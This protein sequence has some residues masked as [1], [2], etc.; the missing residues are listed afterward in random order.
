MKYKVISLRQSTNP[1]VPHTFACRRTKTTAYIIN[2]SIKLNQ[3]YANVHRRKTQT[4]NIHENK[5]L[6]IVYVYPSS[7]K[8]NA[9]V[10]MR[11]FDNTYT[12]GVSIVKAAG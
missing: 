7:T 10:C 12:A 1:M 2:Y 5:T 3:G 9:N 11:L 4:S 6:Y 8:I